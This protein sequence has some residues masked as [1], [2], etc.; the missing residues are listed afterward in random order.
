MREEILVGLMARGRTIHGIGLAI[1]SVGTRVYVPVGRKI[2]NVPSSGRFGMSNCRRGLFEERTAFAMLKVFRKR[3]QARFGRDPE[4]DELLF[5]DPAQEQPVAA[6]PPVIR[7]QVIAAAL[8]ARVDP[9]SV[10]DL[11]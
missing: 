6:E 11:T 3:Y 1:L 2:G 8:A 7:S 9:Q 10:L 4:P 5:F